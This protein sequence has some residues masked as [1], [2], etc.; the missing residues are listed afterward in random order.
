VQVPEMMKGQ[1][2]EM[3]GGTVEFRWRRAW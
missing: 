1:A 2:V 3:H